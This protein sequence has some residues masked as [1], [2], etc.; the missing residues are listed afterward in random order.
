MSDARTAQAVL[1]VTAPLAMGF[2]YAFQHKECMLLQDFYLAMGAMYGAGCFVAAG[3]RL[4]SAVAAWKRVLL[5]PI[6]WLIAAAAGLEI[7]ACRS[8]LSADTRPTILGYC[9]ALAALSSLILLAIRE[10]RKETV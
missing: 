8:G 10:N 2:S 1:F 7:F 6:A 4:M 3:Y 5:L 9:Y